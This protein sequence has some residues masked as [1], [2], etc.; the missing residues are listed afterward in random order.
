MHTQYFDNSTT[1]NKANGKTKLGY[2]EQQFEAP[3]F[4]K[5][6]SEE[7]KAEFAFQL[8]LSIPASRSLEVVDRLCPLLHRDFFSVNPIFIPIL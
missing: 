2:V 3:E 5:T 7:Q 4:V 8:L 6:W 1:K